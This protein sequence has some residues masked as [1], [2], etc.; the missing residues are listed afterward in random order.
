MPCLVNESLERLF[1]ALTSPMASLTTSPNAVVEPI[2]P[3]AMAVILTTAEERD[4]WMS[5]ARQTK[6]KLQRDELTFG[7]TH[8]TEDAGLGREANHGAVRRVVG[9]VDDPIRRDPQP[10]WTRHLPA[11]ID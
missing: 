11:T 5:A 3:K 4:V 2:H 8:E 1:P 7:R 6:I 9:S 10:E